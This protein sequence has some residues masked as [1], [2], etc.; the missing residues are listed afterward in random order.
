MG[1]GVHTPMKREVIASSV[2][3]SIGYDPVWHVLELEFRESGEIYDY[4]E[5]PAE[6]YEAFRN[7]SSKGTY[8]NTIFKAKNYRVVRK[9][10]E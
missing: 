7:A 5:V 8:L 3:A 4:F 1:E 2:I 9:N 6:E 10:S